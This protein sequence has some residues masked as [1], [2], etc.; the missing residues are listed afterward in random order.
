MR[1]IVVIGLLLLALPGKSQVT[2]VSEIEHKAAGNLNKL[3][4]SD[5][6][7]SSYCIIIK[8]EVRAHKHLKHSEHVLV[9]SGEGVLK[10][11]E[12]ETLIKPGDVVFI[13][14]NTTHSVIVKGKHPLK[15]VS[16]QAPYFDGE[17]RVMME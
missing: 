17:D 15:V 3:L 8:S 4:F 11:G 13:P 1:S 9:I 16:I 6:L 12:K 10:L 2:S 5:S 14:K 7:C